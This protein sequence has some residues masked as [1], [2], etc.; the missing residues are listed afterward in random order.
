MW[1]L[2][3]AWPQ[4]QAYIMLSWKVSPRQDGPHW[5]LHSPGT[6][7]KKEPL[8]GLYQ[9]APSLLTDGPWVLVEGSKSGLALS[10]AGGRALAP[11]CC[12]PSPCEDVT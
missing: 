5:K 10:T 7:K 11:L 6:C 9:T 2:R 4:E 1:K 3:K 12:K 8:E